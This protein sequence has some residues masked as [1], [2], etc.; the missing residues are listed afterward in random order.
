M[1]CTSPSTRLPFLAR[2]PYSA[3][4]CSQFTCYSQIGKSQGVVALS[5]APDSQT[6]SE[7]TI[8]RKSSL[9]AQQP[10]HQTDKR[11]E[12]ETVV[13]IW[14]IFTVGGNCL[15]Q[16]DGSRPRKKPRHQ[17]GGWR[18]EPPHY[19]YTVG[20]QLSHNVLCFFNIQITNWAARKLHY[21][22][23]SR[24]NMSKLLYKLS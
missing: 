22:P 9:P 17:G 7:R 6:I 14:T 23:N 2:D 3:S 12:G 11:R 13:S 18:K 15:G 4:I 20:H 16:Q 5:V 1:G 19:K 24:W 8:I 21:Q 10:E